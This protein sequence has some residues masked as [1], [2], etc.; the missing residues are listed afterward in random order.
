MKATINGVAWLMLLIVGCAVED[1]TDQDILARINDYR[2]P[3]AQFEQELADDM[4]MNDA[5]KLTDDARFQFLE[6]MI[7]RELLIQ[8]AK[9]MGLD[10][11]P[12]FV[13]T[14]EKYWEATLIRNLMVHKNQQ[15]MQTVTIDE[16][17]IDAACSKFF[18]S[19]CGSGQKDA[20]LRQKVRAQLLEEKAAEQLEAWAQQLR[21]RAQVKIESHLLN[22]SSSQSPT[23]QDASTSQTAN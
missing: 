21:D 14:I 9:K 22:I 1:T 10:R 5:F 15:L 6:R 16:A 7:R 18:G 13:R 2:L 3:L 4:E 17:Q 8:E 19:A 23:G 20:A 12:E 11:K